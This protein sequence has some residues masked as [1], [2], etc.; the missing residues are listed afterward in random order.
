[1]SK[2]N[3]G[4]G[5]VFGLLIGAVAGAAAAVIMTQDETRDRLAGKAREAGGFAMDATGDLREKVSDVTAAWQ[6][7]VSDLYERGRQ[8]VENARSNLD[9]AVAEGQ[10]TAEQMRDELQRKAEG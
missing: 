1:M 9:A 2:R 10:A 8:V 5:F 4:G 7:G 3:G 6:S